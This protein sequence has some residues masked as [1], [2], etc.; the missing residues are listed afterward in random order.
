MCLSVAH[1]GGVDSHCYPEGR[2]LCIA[3]QLRHKDF[4]AETIHMKPLYLG[5]DSADPKVLVELVKM[6][7]DLYLCSHGRGL[8][9][10]SS[11]PQCGR[12]ANWANEQVIKGMPKT[13]IA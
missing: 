4:F 13:P 9:L 1:K 6:G 2:T 12:W 5:R 11:Q 10:S 7:L 3:S 8:D